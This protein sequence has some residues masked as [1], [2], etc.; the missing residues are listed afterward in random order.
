MYHLKNLYS[1]EL[2][3]TFFRQFAG[4]RLDHVDCLCKI[5]GQ[6]CS[7]YRLDV[8]E[9]G[10]GLIDCLEE[11]SSC[12]SSILKYFK[13]RDLFVSR[14]PVYP[15]MFRYRHVHTG[16]QSYRHFLQLQTDGFFLSDFDQ[17]LDCQN[18]DENLGHD[19]D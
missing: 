15:D 14:S 13:V 6:E 12:I 3:R 8:Y 11:V 16:L 4:R 1:A 9:I 10:I 5:H 7:L 18:A 2:D 17:I 19:V